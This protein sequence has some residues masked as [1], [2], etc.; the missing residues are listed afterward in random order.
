M[1]SC[2]D[3]HIKIGFVRVFFSFFLILY[4]IFSV[5]EQQEW[6]YPTVQVSWVLRVT[7]GAHQ[8]GCSPTGPE[9]GGVVIVAGSTCSLGQVR[10]MLWIQGVQLG[11]NS[12]G[13]LRIKAMA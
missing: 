13:W 5:R 11:G 1:I 9:Q 10:V 6:A 3:S 2:I 8:P 7:T 12:R 4:M